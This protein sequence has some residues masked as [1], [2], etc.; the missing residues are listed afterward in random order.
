M[1][2]VII[3]GSTLHTLE[4]AQ[5]LAND[6]RFHINAVLTPVPKPVGRKQVVTKNPLHEFAEKNEIPVVFVEKKINDTLKAE[7][8][9]Y[10]CDILLVVDFGYFVPNWLLELP[11]IG[12]V[13]IHP[14]DLPRYRGSSPGQFA[15]V[16]GERNSAITLIRMDEKLDH[17]PVISKLFFPVDAN[18]KAVDYYAHAFMVASRQLPELLEAY[19]KNPKNLTP[20]PD[21]SPTPVARMLSRTDGFVP[22]EALKNIS[23]DGVSAINIPFLAGYGLP[24][25]TE[26]LYNLWRGLTPWPG[27]WTEIE[28]KRVKLLEMEISAGKLKLTKIQLEGRTPTADLI[29]LGL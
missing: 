24:A 23:R 22:F 18:W 15:L 4:C 17:G 1:V 7:L 25:S 5:T 29:K 10:P 11:S 26:N 6:S 12:P 9:A 19:L 28:G 14:S 16:F 8:S 13:N 20:Q 2:Q 3:A 27:I 21:E